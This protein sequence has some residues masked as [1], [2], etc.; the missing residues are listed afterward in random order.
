MV[1]AQIEHG[2]KHMIKWMAIYSIP[3]GTDPDEQWRTPH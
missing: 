1:A 3:E 2:R